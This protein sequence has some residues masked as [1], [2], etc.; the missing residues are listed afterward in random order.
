MARNGALRTERNLDVWLPAHFYDP[1]QCHGGAM[2]DLGCRPMY[3]ARHILGLPETVNSHYRYVTGRAVED[4]VVVTLGYASGAPAVVEAG[5]VTPALPFT[6]EVHS[7]C[8]S[9]IYSALPPV[10][11]MRGLDDWIEQAI[12][13]SS[14]LPFVQWVDHIQRGT[15]NVANIDAALDLTKPMEA[16]NRSAAERRQVRLDSL[17]P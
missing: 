1:D 14:P 12:P 2:I 4:N 11:R 17:Q 15:R 16:A 8:T 9:L 13:K 6:I 7:T 3:L 5:F 10:L